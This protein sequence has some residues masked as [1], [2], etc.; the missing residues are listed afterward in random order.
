M[1][2]DGDITCA[3]DSSMGAYQVVWHAHYEVDPWVQYDVMH[4]CKASRHK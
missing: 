4:A 3:C 2:F 1:D